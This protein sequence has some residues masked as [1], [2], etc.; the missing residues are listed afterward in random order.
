MHRASRAIVRPTSRRSVWCWYTVGVVVVALL[1]VAIIAGLCNGW[2]SSSVV[3][4]FDPTTSAPVVFRTYTDTMRTWLT[5]IH[6][7]LATYAPSLVSNG[8]TLP[9]RLAAIDDEKQLEDIAQAAGMRHDVHIRLFVEGASSQRATPHVPA[10]TYTTLYRANAGWTDTNQADATGEGGG[11][12]GYH[13]CVTADPAEATSKCTY[14][15]IRVGEVVWARYNVEN[16]ASKWAEARVTAVYPKNTLPRMKSMAGGDTHTNAN[17]LFQQVRRFTNNATEPRVRRADF[18]V[19][20]GV[21]NGGEA[22][23]PASLN[24]QGYFEAPHDEGTRSPDGGVTYPVEFVSVPCV[25]VHLVF[26]NDPKRVPADTVGRT[27]SA[28]AMS[29]RLRNMYDTRVRAKDVH[30]HPPMSIVDEAMIACVHTNSSNRYVQVGWTNGNESATEDHSRHHFAGICS[31]RAE[32]VNTLKDVH[33]TGESSNVYERDDNTLDQTAL[34]HTLAAHDPT[35]GRTRAKRTCPVVA[36]PTVMSGDG[37]GGADIVVP[38]ACPCASSSLSAAEV[39]DFLNRHKPREFRIGPQCTPKGPRDG[40][41][42]VT[43]ETSCP[44]QYDIPC[45]QRPRS[46]DG[47]APFCERMDTQNYQCTWYERGDALDDDA[48]RQHSPTMTGCYDADACLFLD[49]GDCEDKDHK[50][51]CKW[52]AE[53]AQCV[54]HDPCPTTKP[55]TVDDLHKLQD[56]GTYKD[57]VARRKTTKAVNAEHAHLRTSSD[58]I[59]ALY[60]S[61]AAPSSDDAAYTTLLQRMDLLTGKAPRQTN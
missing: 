23:T 26:I 22:A 48:Q 10:S 36:S 12:G 53:W 37:V 54:P 9:E 21:S 47:G 24:P 13:G 8:H 31:A 44:G 52:K 50:D 32:R 14:V 7:D 19:P 16:G 6:P 2:S 1:V 45:R 5:S 61:T 51:R 46:T 39:Q 43:T 11:A 59:G 15:P 38:T 58:A 3:E 40:E 20:I 57:A 60:A 30:R 49:E 33:T 42:P 4:T 28:G 56:S 34:Q 55:V 18:V 27:T 41:E 17:H 35:S 25:T 29:A